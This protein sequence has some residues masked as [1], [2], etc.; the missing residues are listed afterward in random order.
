MERES[1]VNTWTRLALLER[2]ATDLGEIVK[3]HEKRIR[4]TERVALYGIG[5]VGLGGF[6]LNVYDHLKR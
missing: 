3:D 6:I 5:A 1:P 4:W 2:T